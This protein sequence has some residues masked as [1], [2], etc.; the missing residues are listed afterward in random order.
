MS[1][2]Y[3]CNV[4]TTSMLDSEHAHTF[5]FDPISED[6]ARGILAVSE[7]EQAV[8][9]PATCEVLSQRLGLK[10]KPTR[11]NVRL[12]AGDTLIVA[13]VVVPRLAEGKIMSNSTPMPEH[14]RNEYNE[15][16]YL[17]HPHDA[18]TVNAWPAGTIA[19][20]HEDGVIL[21][22]PNDPITPVLERVDPEVD[23]VYRKVRGI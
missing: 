15:P 5:K 11:A 8:G 20:Y 12:E 16:L 7:F 18:A 22:I 4:F 1:K 9:H 21:E 6:N 10:V 17:R 19:T 14:M 13:Q 23:G 3:L 2:T